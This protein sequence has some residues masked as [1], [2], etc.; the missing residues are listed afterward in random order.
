MQQCQ[1]ERYVCSLDP[2]HFGRETH[3]ARLFY[4]ACESGRWSVSENLLLISGRALDL[5]SVPACRHPSKP[6]QASQDFF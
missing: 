2:Y 4:A 1:S 6:I 5:Q 3:L